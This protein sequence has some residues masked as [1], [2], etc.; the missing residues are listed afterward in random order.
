MADA[1][2]I[3]SLEDLLNRVE[4]RLIPEGSTIRVS[5]DRPDLQTPLQLNEVM[6]VL[7]AYRV[8]LNREAGLDQNAIIVE[9]P[10]G[11]AKPPA[12]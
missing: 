6:D 11:K 5:K 12:F 7:T 3:T 1:P 8:K 4:E 10:P 2:P 9:L